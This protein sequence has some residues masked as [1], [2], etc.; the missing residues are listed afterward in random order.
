M[1]AISLNGIRDLPPGDAPLPGEAMAEDQERA[2][3]AMGAFVRGHRTMLLRDTDWTQ[4]ADNNLDAQQRASFA[5]YR[6]LLR[7]I[8]EQAGFPFVAW[9]QAPIL[10][11]G[12]G[13]ET[14]EQS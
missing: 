14:G 8:P 9:P 2:L 6:S 10:Q 3:V 13:S 1:K 11:S 5:A 4:I 7:D 12:A